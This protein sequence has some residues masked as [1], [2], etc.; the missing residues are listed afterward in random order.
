MSFPAAQQAAARKTERPALKQYAALLWRW[1]WLIV[2]GA[3]LGGAAALAVSWQTIP[4]YQASTAL[5]V[6]QARATSSGPDYNALLTGERLAKTYAEL[7]RKRPT[8]EAVI[9]SLK[10]DGDAEALAKRVTVAPVLDTQLLVLTVEDSDPQR[11]ADIANQIVEGVQPAKPGAAGRP[12]WRHQAEPGA[13][14]GQDLAGY[15]QHAGRPGR[16]ENSGRDAPSATVC[17]RCWRSIVRTMR[18][19]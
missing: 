15:R 17:R 13:R 3:M 19:C 2:L 6:N 5:L 11:A 18:R 8:L 1:A 9:A 12:V 10:L 7:M 4:V 16:P 14:A